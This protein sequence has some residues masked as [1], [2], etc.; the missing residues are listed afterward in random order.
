M[1]DNIPLFFSFKN[2]ETCEDGNDLVFFYQVCEGVA[3]ASHASHTA[4][5]AGLPEKLVARGKEVRSKQ[6]PPPSGLAPTVPASPRDLDFWAHGIS[7]PY[8]LL[9]YPTPTPTSAPSS[10]VLGL[11]LDLQWKA[12]QACQGAAKGETNGKVSAGPGSLFSLACSAA[13]LPLSGTQ[14]ASCPLKI[15]NFFLKFLNSQGLRFPVL[16]PLPSAQGFCYPCFHKSHCSLSPQLPD[17]SK[18]VS[19]TG[20]GRSQS[21]PGHFHESGSAACCHHHPLSVLPGLSSTS[22]TPGGCQ[23]LFVSLLPSHPEIGRAHV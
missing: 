9:S 1:T 6:Q 8:S 20:F 19:E 21:G 10:L 16:H 15:Q 22:Q 12:H 2:M 7:D 17:V 5:Q 23:A 18:Q 3:N 14:T 11:R 4:A 13:L